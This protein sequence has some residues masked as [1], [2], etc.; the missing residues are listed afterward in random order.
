MFDR[1]RN[2]VLNISYSK[3]VDLDIPVN[4]AEMFEVG[5]KLGFD[6]IKGDVC[7]TSDGK[8]IMCHDAEFRF[9][10]NGRVFESGNTT[11][12]S[13]KQ[14]CDMTYDECTQLEYELES[15]KAQ[16]GYYAKVVGLEDLI[17]IC[18]IHSKFAYITVRDK[19]IQTCVDEVY[20]LLLKYNMTNQCIINSFT[21]ETLKT[22][23]EKDENICLSHVQEL[24]IPVSKEMIDT[25]L[26]LKK[27][28][29]CAYWS[30]NKDGVFDEMYEK[31]KEAMEYAKEKGVKLFLAFATNKENHKLA[32]ERGFTGFQCQRSEV[33]V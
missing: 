5:C 31:S 33:L 3:L 7:P 1:I 17:R 4:T 28:V 11:G 24:D 20:R 8:L 15:S 27:C 18:H 6:G 29:V 9:D 12:V 30:V 21:Y 26:E 10:E 16:L 2:E 22:V 14:I 25:A 32:I 13:V 19:Q 23:R